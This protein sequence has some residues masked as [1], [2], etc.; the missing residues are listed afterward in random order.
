MKSNTYPKPQGKVGHS[1]MPSSETIV[2]VSTQSANAGIIGWVEN[3]DTLHQLI[4]DFRPDAH[5]THGSNLAAICFRKVPVWCDFADESH[6]IISVWFDISISSTRSIG[7]QKGQVFGTLS[8]FQYSMMTSFSQTFGKFEL[9]RH[10]S[11]TS[12]WLLHICWNPYQM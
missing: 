9:K 10:L 7:I 2:R 6:T 3:C 5:C 1:T 4:K 12:K 11:E 8:E